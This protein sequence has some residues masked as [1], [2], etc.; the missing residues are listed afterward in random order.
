MNTDNQIGDSMHE[1]TCEIE[2]IIDADSY[3]VAIDCGFGISFR[4]T[5][6]LAGVD[7][8]ESRTR[9]KT[10]KIYGKAATAF[11]KEHLKYGL[12]YRIKTEKAGKF[13]RYLGYIYVDGKTSINQLLIDNHHAVE[14]HGQSKADVAKL[15]LLNREILRLEDTNLLV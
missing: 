1:Y 6:R 4:T 11:A 12:R 14:Y 13:G 7:T 9:D 8:P 15:H 10:E 5:I 3:R 2:R